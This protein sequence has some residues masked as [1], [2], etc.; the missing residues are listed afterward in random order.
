MSRFTGPRNSKRPQPIIYPSLVPSPRTPLHPG[1]APS[2][3]RRRPLLAINLRNGSCAWSWPKSISMACHS[4]VPHLHSPH[5]HAN[6]SRPE[7]VCSL[8]CAGERAALTGTRV[9]L[10]PLYH[11]NF[12]GKEKVQGKGQTPMH[13]VVCLG[14]ATPALAEESLKLSQPIWSHPPASRVTHS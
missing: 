11:S 2:S 5:T 3:H 14:P 1:I 8:T 9:C 6:G 12:Y 10:P 7:D 4:E 13:R